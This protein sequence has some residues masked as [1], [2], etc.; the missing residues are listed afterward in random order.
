MGKAFAGEN[1]EQVNTFLPIITAWI[2]AIIAYCFS[3]KLTEAYTRAMK[4]SVKDTA[5]SSALEDIN[6]SLYPPYEQ[7]S[8]KNQYDIL[9]ENL[10]TTPLWG[11]ENDHIRKSKKEDN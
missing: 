9:F 2:G 7:K 11:D 3:D 5:K 8:G 6:K 4:D 10:K 1:V